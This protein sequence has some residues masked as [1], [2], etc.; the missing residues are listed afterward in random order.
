MRALT[1]RPEFKGSCKIIIYIE[2]MDALIRDGLLFSLGIT[3]MYMPSSQIFLSII[4]SA[5][6]S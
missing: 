6:R 3:N 1:C 5:Y 2:A 4:N